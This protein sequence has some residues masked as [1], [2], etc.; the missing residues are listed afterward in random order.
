MYV[1]QFVQYD[2]IIYLEYNYIKCNFSTFD[3]IFFSYTLCMKLK[4]NLLIH[5][6]I[7]YNEMNVIVG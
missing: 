2:I 4:K 3:N 5:A 6:T 7:M 1:V